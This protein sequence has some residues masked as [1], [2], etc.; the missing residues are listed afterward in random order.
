MADDLNDVIERAAL[1]LQSMVD[2]GF[3]PEDDEG[4]Y[5]AFGGKKG[6]GK[7]AVPNKLTDKQ[8]LAYFDFIGTPLTSK[9]EK[10]S[11]IDAIRQKQQSA[12]SMSTENKR[13]STEQK[14]SLTLRQLFELEA[15]SKPDGSVPAEVASHLKRLEGIVD[16]ATGTPVLDMVVKDMDVGQVIGDVI[17]EGEFREADLKASPTLRTRSSGLITRLNTMFDNAGFGS[18]YVK[19]QVENSLGKDTFNKE[20]GWEYKRQRKIVVGFQ[21]DV[22]QKLKGI[23][24]DESLP[25]ELRNQMAGHLFGGFRPENISQF[26]I[27]NYDKEKGILTFF[28]NKSKK[29]KFLVV[30]PAVQGIINEQ[31]GDRTSGLIF[32]NAKDNQTKLNTL[33]TNTMEKVTFAKPDGS[34]KSENFT[35]YKLRNLNETILTDSGLSLDDI[36][37][38]NGRKPQSEAAGYVTMA[39]RQRRINRA[40]NELVASIAGYSGTQSVAQFSADIGI[41][42]PEKSLQT[43]VSRDLLVADEY[44]EAL[45][46]EFID[47]LESESGTYSK[48]AIPPA[49]PEQAAQYKKEAIAQSQLREET[50]LSQA[51]S[52]RKTRLEEAGDVEKLD[53]D[54][55]RQKIRD[56]EAKKRIEADELAKIKGELDLTGDISE[57]GKSLF[58][59]LG[60]LDDDTKLGIGIGAGLTA[61]GVI[62][63]PDKAEAASEV[64]RDVAIDVAGEAG[65]KSIVGRTIAGRVPIAD[66]LIPSA[67]MADQEAT[68]DMRPLTQEMVESNFRQREAERAA[69][70]KREATAEAAMQEGDS[71]MTMQP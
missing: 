54:V 17:S 70:R 15:T 67:S 19:K 64:A 16:K 42:F 20:S 53:E 6:A 25:K 29:N 71:F 65:L 63:A 32:P 4:L 48:E 27:E 23:L 69:R 49:D 12:P 28:D 22:Y 39:S 21:S 55:I 62:A 34:I 26:K 59:R 31:I 61:I 18:G 50:A 68:P 38:L 13:L 52:V 45:P 36:N 60:M 43:V 40:A 3:I 7:V 33:L 47:T 24:A 41:P 44:V 37:F 2:T 5:E 8:I 10:A 9:S 56:R 58:K 35:V 1:D 11:V 57:E 66:L 30:N 46:D 51:Q 14:K